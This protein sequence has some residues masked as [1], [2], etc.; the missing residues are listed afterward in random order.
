MVRVTVASPTLTDAHTGGTDTLMNTINPTFP[1]QEDI[2]VAFT[3]L[4]PELQEQYTLLKA[5]YEKAI[6]SDPPDHKTIAEL[7]KQGQE[8]LKS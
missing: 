2:N 7:I 5:E 3:S 8:L 4:S 6:N 1:T